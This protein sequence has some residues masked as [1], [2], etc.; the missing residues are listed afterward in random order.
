MAAP[1]K[2]SLS[3]MGTCSFLT[4]S[5][6]SQNSRQAP[7]TRSVTMSNPDMPC[8]MASL[9]TGAIR[10]QPAQARNM[11]KWAMSG[12]LL[13]LLLFV[14]DLLSLLKIIALYTDSTP[15]PIPY[16]RSL[17]CSLFPQGEGVIAHSLRQRDSTVGKI[18]TT[19]HITPLPSRRVSYTF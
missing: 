18:N 19:H 5:D 6:V 17:T 2:R 14:N 10:P 12:R 1:T 15:A 7:H 13:S 16:M 4:N 9:P 3:C 8:V 11:D